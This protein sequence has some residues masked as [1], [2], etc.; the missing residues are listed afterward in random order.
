MLIVEDE[1]A[2]GL[3]LL[4]EFQDHGYHAILTADA[5]TALAAIA[6]IRIH[7]AILDVGLPGLKGDELARQL[8]KANPSMPIIISTGLSVEQ[9]ATDIRSDPH[10]IVM[11]KPFDVRTIVDRLR[12]LAPADF[13]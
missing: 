5:E 6:N 10:V 3:S 11:Q 13:S 12:L 1:A 7:G 9:V 4:V 2:M 8:R